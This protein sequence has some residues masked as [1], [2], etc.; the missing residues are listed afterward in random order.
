MTGWDLRVV[1]VT[2]EGGDYRKYAVSSKINLLRE[3]AVLEMI[4]NHPGVAYSLVTIWDY[5][6]YEAKQMLQRTAR[7]IRHAEHLRA[8]NERIKL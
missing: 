1:V 2:Q 3:P 7:M 8:L 5:V 6:D 4:G